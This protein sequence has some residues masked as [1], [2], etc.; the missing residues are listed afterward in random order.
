VIF[1]K[2]T[3]FHKKFI[4]NKNLENLVLKLW[5]QFTKHPVCCDHQ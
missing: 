5:P 3:H 1:E 4:N 2:S